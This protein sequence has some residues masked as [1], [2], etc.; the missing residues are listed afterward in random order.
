M[1]TLEQGS[2]FVSYSLSKHNVIIECR[3]CHTLRSY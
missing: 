2:A 1:I 3:C